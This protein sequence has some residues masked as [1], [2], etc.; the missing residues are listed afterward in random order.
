MKKL[1]IIALLA[2]AGCTKEPDCM[3]MHMNGA[4]FEI[5]SEQVIC[6]ES[7]DGEAKMRICV[8]EPKAE[9]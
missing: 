4:Q 9:K 1:M 8:F 7:T 2:L 5:C 6:N 3:H